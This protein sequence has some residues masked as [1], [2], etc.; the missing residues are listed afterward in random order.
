MAP[1]PTPKSSCPAG[2]PLKGLA[3]LKNSEPPLA[4]ED[5]EYPSWLWSL[6]SPSTTDVADT[7]DEGDLFSKS[8]KQRRLASRAARKQAALLEA[9]PELATGPKIPLEQQS[10][11][12]PAGDG[13][14]EEAAEARVVRESLTEAMR[15]TRRSGIKEANF[16]KGIR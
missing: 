13:S 3:Y 2:T 4:K 15:K 1:L 5:H 16:L 7:A 14:L 9:H 11:D 10:I 8:K 12:L 6:L